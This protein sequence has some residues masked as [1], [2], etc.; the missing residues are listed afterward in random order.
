MRFELHPDDGTLSVQAPGTQ[1]LEWRQFDLYASEPGVHVALNELPTA[2]HPGIQAGSKLNLGSL[3][4]SVVH[5]GDVLR[6]CGPPEAAVG[7]SDAGWPHTVE[8]WSVRLPACA[9]SAAA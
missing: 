5:V 8:L 7:L 6:L 9:P 4:G 3:S 2:S 1:P